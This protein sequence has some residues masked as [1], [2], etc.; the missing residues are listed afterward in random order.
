[1]GQG[2][3]RLLFAQMLKNMLKVRGAREGQQQLC[4]FLAFIE[5]V[6]PWF[7]EEGTVDLQTW[8]RVG[9]NLQ[10]YYDTRGPTKVPIGTFGL[11]NLLK[12]SLD[13]R[14]ERD[15]VQE[16]LHLEKQCRPTMKVNH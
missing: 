2:H 16:P 11:W 4:N 6:C 14:H 3:S 15:K 5:K 8:K 9:Q 13:L 7:P 12:D 10:E 1:M